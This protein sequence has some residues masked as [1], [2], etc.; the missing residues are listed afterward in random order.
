MSYQDCNTLLIWARNA[1]LRSFSS[2]MVKWP[3]IFLSVIPNNGKPTPSRTKLHGFL[4]RPTVSYTDYHTHHVRLT[5]MS[6]LISPPPMPW[7]SVPHFYLWPPHQS[8]QSL[9]SLVSVYLC[10][11]CTITCIISLI[12]PP[13]TVC[14]WHYAKFPLSKYFNMSQ[15]ETKKGIFIYLYSRIMLLTENRCSCG[16]WPGIPPI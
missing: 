9:F 16:R 15:Y 5:R 6:E 12:S 10:W 13:G 3:G 7:I 2:N 14:P 11:S 4:R 8:F 1:E